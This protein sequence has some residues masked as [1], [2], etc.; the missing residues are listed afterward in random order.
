MHN[1]MYDDDKKTTGK[2]YMKR[3][4]NICDNNMNDDSIKYITN[5]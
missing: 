5:M 4:E 2:I 3:I 1:I